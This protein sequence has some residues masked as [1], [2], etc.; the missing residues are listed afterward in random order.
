MRT[1]YA[2]IGLAWLV[3]FIG[4]YALNHNFRSS[5]HTEEPTISSSMSN[6]SLASA[7]FQSDGTIP[8]KFTCDGDQVNPP[9][10]ITGVPEGAK[11]LALIMDD[12]DVPKALKPGGV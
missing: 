11:S 12:P 2:L 4:L 10:S 9:L 3:I 7:A 8:A 1:A 6:L 5:D